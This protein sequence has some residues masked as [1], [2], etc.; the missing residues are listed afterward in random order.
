MELLFKQKIILEGGSG[1][2][3]LLVHL[4]DQ[5]EIKFFSN[6]SLARV[7][8][9]VVLVDVIPAQALETLSPCRDPKYLK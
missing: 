4:S 1:G 6:T 9:R 2:C 3:C 8:F 5:Q 7:G